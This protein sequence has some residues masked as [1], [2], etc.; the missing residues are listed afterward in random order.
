MD[1]EV[2]EIDSASLFKST[3][4]LLG[5]PPEEIQISEQER[6]GVIERKD[7]LI[8]CDLATRSRSYRR[9]LQNVSKPVLPSRMSALQKHLQTAFNGGVTTALKVWF[10]VILAARLPKVCK[11]R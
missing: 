5:L 6:L 4:G 11:F 3:R 9:Q 10:L 1:D 7:G 8:G 2:V